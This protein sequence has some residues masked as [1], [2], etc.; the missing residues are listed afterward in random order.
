MITQRMDPRVRGLPALALSA[1]IAVSGCAETEIQGVIRD[2][3][4]ITET[5]MLPLARGINSEFGDIFLASQAQWLLDGPTDGILNDGT[6]AAEVDNA[7]ADFRNRPHSSTWA[8]AHE[9]VWATLFGA[10]RMR[11]VL[12]PEEFQTSPLAARIYLY[13]GH[14][15]RILGEVFCEIVYNYGKDG[16]IFLGQDGPYDGSRLVPNDSAFKRAVAMFE[17]GLG[18]AERAAAAGVQAPEGDP[19]FE[20]SF[21]VTAAHGGLAQA[22]ALLG[23]WNDAVQHARMV[24]DNF[25]DWALMDSE[26][27]G[28]ND[29]A[30]FFYQNDDVSLYRTP[31]ALLW[32]D[33]P[34]VALA[35]CGDW[36]GANMDNRTTTPPASAF[37]NMSAQCGNTAGE[38][39]SESNRYPLWISKKYVDDSADIEVVSGPEMRLIEAEAALVAGNL[40]EFTAQVNRARAARGVGPI[41][42]PATAGQ[43]EYP[44]AEDDGWSILDRERYLE[45]LGEARRFGDLRRWDHPFVSGNHILVPRHNGQLA[46]EGRW[47]CLPLPDQEC[48]TNG[49]ITCPTLA[50]G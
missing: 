42:A 12:T 5:L 21:L 19:I 18:F 4:L 23:R 1:I 26:V 11:E 31:A 2:E 35:K 25:A 32:P 6:T 34:R 40:A 10:N 24:P 15:E 38:F 28:G 17:T 49:S 47:K 14:A 7:I 36:S 13:A 43:L 29:L 48:D 44:N 30:D 8:Q 45:F 39:R 16:G 46:P 20:P 41:T 22:Y 9:A 27:D 33:D 3:D 37:R 50:S